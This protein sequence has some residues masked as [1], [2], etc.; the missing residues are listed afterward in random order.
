[1]ALIIDL[2]GIVGGCR[3]TKYALLAF[4]AVTRSYFMRTVH[5]FR[6]CRLDPSSHMLR[7]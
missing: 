5:V 1:M 6:L 4:G 3:G 7:Q 2:G